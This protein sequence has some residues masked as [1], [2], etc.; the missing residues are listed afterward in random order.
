MRLSSYGLALLKELEGCVLQAYKDEAG[1]W[2]IGYGH[3]GKEVIKGLRVTS[4][5]A[6]D[7]LIKDLSVFERGVENAIAKPLTQD[8]F[9]A[10]TLFAFNVGLG[11]LLGSTLRK[12]II[13]GSKDAADEFLKWNKI[14][15]DGKKME[16]RVLTLRRQKER[17]LFLGKKV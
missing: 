6:E 13:A 15:V 3:T 10:L 12:K 8:Q 2:T 4:Q 11:A 1:V 9:D 17:D 14:T 7:L 5:Q 16:S